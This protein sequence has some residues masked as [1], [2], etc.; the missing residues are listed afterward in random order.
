MSARAV[1]AAAVVA[2]LRE[3]PALAGVA[4][5]DAPPVRG[6]LPHLVVEEAVLGDWGTKSWAGHEARLAVVI[7]D[8][9]ERPVRLRG[10]LGDVEAA[11]TALPVV[12]GEGWRIADTRVVRSRVARSGAERWVGSVE[13]VVRMWREDS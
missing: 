10:L 5:F 6:T 8:A 4:V 3:H 7:W 11:V 12:L 13:I 1:L 9:G 2:T